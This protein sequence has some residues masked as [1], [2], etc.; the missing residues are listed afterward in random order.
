MLFCDWLDVAP[1]VK[2]E[3]SSC[4]SSRTSNHVHLEA[5]QFMGFDLQVPK[6][7]LRWEGR[8]ASG[9]TQAGKP[10]LFL[11][12]EEQPDKSHHNAHC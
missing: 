6:L 4:R 3:D 7:G 10:E 9:A 5:T 2:I 12:E 1:A 8:R 11:S